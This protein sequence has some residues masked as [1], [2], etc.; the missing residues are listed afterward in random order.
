MKKILFGCVLALLAVTAGLFGQSQLITDSLTQIDSTIQAMPEHKICGHRRHHKFGPR[1]HFEI[2]EGNS[3]NWSGYV[4]ATNLSHPVKGSVSAVIGSWIVP[5]LSSSSHPTYSSIWV[6]IDGFSN[7][8]VEQ[9][10]TEQDWYSGGQ[11]NFAWFEMYPSGL[12]E[13][14][15]FPVNVNDHMAAEVVYEGNGV[16]SMT[17][18]NYT[19]NVYTVIPT[20]YTTSLTAQR[21]SAE[22]IVEA[23][24]SSSGVLPLAHFGTAALSSC[25]AEINGVVGAINNGHWANEPLTMVTQNGIVKAV[26]SNLGSGGTSFTVSWEHE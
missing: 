12:Y 16:F 22:W 8:T 17:I 26:P 18:V 3:L 15:G 20:S 19:H 14:V 24:S 5:H 13:I 21:S 1:P 2:S 7:A 4:A 23:P 6:G 9:I 25:E 11:H 10:G